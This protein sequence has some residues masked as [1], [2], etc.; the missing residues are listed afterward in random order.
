MS[1][2]T[3][4][5]FRKGSRRPANAGRR[6]GTPNRVSREVKEFLADVLKKPEVQDAVE[7]RLLKGDMVAFFKAVE[8]VHGKARQTL[9]V[10][11][12]EFRMIQWPGTEDIAEE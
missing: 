5:R 1:R 10:A 3:S 2:D 12:G 6:R 7:A 11:P 8:I 4:G 9:A